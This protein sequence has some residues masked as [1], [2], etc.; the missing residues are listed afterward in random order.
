MQEDCDP[1][2]MVY[3]VVFDRS[4]LLAGSELYAEIAEYIDDHYADSRIDRRRNADMEDFAAGFA[5]DMLKMS[6][7]MAAPAS[8]EDVFD[9]LDESFSQMVLRKIDEKGFVKDS[10][11]YKA[12]NID[13]KLFSKIRS[14]MD[15]KPKKTTALALAIALKLSLEETKELLM[16]AGYSLS[17][18]SKMDLFVEYFIVN[19]IYD[20]LIINEALYRFDQPLLGGRAA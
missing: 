2:L 6:P 14:D 3:L 9:M 18:S 8:L 11:C 17:H 19:G 13:R 7:S 5:P 12:A 16:K 1:D 20:I 4:S 15:Y 10:D